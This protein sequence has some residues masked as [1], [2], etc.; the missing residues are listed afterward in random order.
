M[1]KYVGFHAVLCVTPK[2]I[3]FHANI[4]IICHLHTKF[5]YAQKLLHIWNVQYA[6]HSP[7]PPP[8]DSCDFARLSTN[9]ETAD[10]HAQ[11][12]E[13]VA[14]IFELPQHS[15]HAGTK[16]WQTKPAVWLRQNQMPATDQARL[17]TG[18]GGK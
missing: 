13:L 2:Y 11:I 14:C 4:H 9:I 7:A 16:V 10:M 17:G 12:M 3:G 15:N 1:P 6:Q 8:L 5:G 18:H